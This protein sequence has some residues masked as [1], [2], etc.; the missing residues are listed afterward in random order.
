MIEI[1]VRPD[2]LTITGHARAGPPGQDI[3][4]SAISTLFETLVRSIRKL[5]DDQ[6]EY[7]IS[8]GYAGLRY[9]HLSEK[10]RTLIDAFFIGCCGIAGS[11]PEYV[12][13]S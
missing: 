5:T 10:S 9:K 4:C 1:K 11:Y 8:S 7:E 2:H 3:V 12:A 6:I 13:I